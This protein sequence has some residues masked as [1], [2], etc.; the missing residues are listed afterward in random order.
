MKNAN[1]YMIKDLVEAIT[2]LNQDVMANRAT[3]V[4]LQNKVKKLEQDLEE[5]NDYIYTDKVIR[6]QRYEK[7]I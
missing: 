1:E 2:R 3:L 5:V 7:L 4:L 6:K